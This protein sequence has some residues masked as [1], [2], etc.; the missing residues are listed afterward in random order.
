MLSLLL[1][2]TDPSPPLPHASLTAT[3]KLRP[4]KISEALPSCFWSSHGSPFLQLFGRRLQRAPHTQHHTHV[5]IARE[6]CLADV[7]TGCA[8][9]R[10]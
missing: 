10:Q 8:A 9:V 1:S 2:S 7:N 6:R 3:S 4:L 5:S